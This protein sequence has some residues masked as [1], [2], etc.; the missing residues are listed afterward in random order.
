MSALNTSRC[1]IGKRDM[2]HHDRTY[3]QIRNLPSVKP[4]F[5][6]TEIAIGRANS[7]VDRNTPTNMLES[8]GE[9]PKS[10]QTWIS[11]GLQQDI[12]GIV[13]PVQI[14][15]IASSEPL[16]QTIRNL[17]WFGPVLVRPHT[18]CANMP[19]NLESVYFDKLSKHNLAT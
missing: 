2:M 18:Y 17:T 5:R 19:S 15:H 10:T 7:V 4:R 14:L 13:G 9:T 8:Q 1:C 16:S 3:P 6:S 12:L 11:I